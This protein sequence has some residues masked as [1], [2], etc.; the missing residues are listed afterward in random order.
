M[1]S[2]P[3]QRTRFQQFQV[4]LG[5]GLREQVLRS[6]RVASL[7]LLSLLVGFFVAQ[8]VGGLLLAQLPGGRPLVVLGLVLLVEALVRLRSQ[9]VRDQPPLGWVI[10]DNLRIGAV[11]AIVLEAFKLGT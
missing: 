11:Y 8:N 1:M 10:V 4:R 6:W 2:P 9:V 5:S 7:T 3:P